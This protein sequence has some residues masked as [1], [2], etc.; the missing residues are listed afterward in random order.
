MPQQASSNPSTHGDGQLLTIPEVRARC[1]LSEKT[2]RRAIDR[3][4]LRA[5]KLCNRIRI[6]SS[7]FDAWL[8]RAVIATIDEPR[9]SHRAPHQPNPA[10]PGG[11][12]ELLHE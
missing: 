4:E 9:P 10:T 2:I 8:A 6:T 11:L 7:D 3:G 12:R 5:L 1:H